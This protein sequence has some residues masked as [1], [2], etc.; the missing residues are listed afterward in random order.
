M[1]T[2]AYARY[3]SD[4]QREASIRDQLRN[5]ETYCE[6]AGWPTPAL[7]QDQA[8]SGSRTDRPGYQAMLDAA[9]E[10]RFDVLLV[11]DF[12]RLSRDHIEA[13][14]TVRTL[15]FLGI[16]L[17]GVSDGLDTGRS[18]YKLET[19][20]R[21]L[22]AEL[23]LDD[24]AEKT[25]RGLMGQALEGYSAGGLPYGYDSSNPDGKGARRRICEEEARWVRWI[26]EQYVAG[27][28]PRAIV[29]ELN[30]R[31][32]PSPRGGK[33]AA[34]AIYPDAKGVGMLGNAIY[35]GRQVWNKTKWV[36]DPASGR[37]R[38]TLRPRSEWVITE[39]ED[40]KIID[41]ATWAAAEARTRAIRAKTAQQR[42][43][44]SAATGGGGGPKYLFSG[45]L[46]CGCCG[47]AYVVMDRYRYGCATNKDRGDSACPNRMRVSRK[48]IEQVLLAGIKAELL[49]EAAYR[50]FEDEARRLLKTNKPDAG[51]AKRDVAKAKA[52]VDNI[53]AA[54]R[55]GIITPST[56]KAMEEA[57]TRLLEAERRLV[58]VQ[59]FQPAQI[60]PR[61]REIHRAL[62]EQLECIEDVA[63][64]REAIRAIVGEIRLVPDG[65][66][67]VAEMTNAGM[68]GACQ[69]ALVAGAGFERRLTPFRVRLPA[70]RSRAA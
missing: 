27:L 4:S 18:G 14:Q 52:E 31:G 42:Q 43:S 17:I 29:A 16:R 12:S 55:A 40:L 3:S 8:I 49:S 38:R 60:L 19:G 46:R 34:T 63:A 1:R 54:I 51:E 68:A 11:D 33:W 10:G 65:G 41:G 28:S 35:T 25:H 53:L 24:L 67:L 45:L 56:K 22:M 66:E 58:E 20:F 2:A 15:K 48:V 36:K 69:M 7:F 6:R 64:A 5:V 9:R 32:V 37:R 61:A 21:G 59:G 57:E 70:S 26:F 50:A 62:V 30:S 44:G 13:A 39:H 47:G 23:Y